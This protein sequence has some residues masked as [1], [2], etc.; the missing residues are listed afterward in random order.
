M[1]KVVKT[2]ESLARPVVEE[3]GLTLWDVEFV[4]E[5]GRWV[6]RVL[7]DCQDGVSVNQCQAVSLALDPLLDE[8]DPI[9]QSYVLQ[10]SSAGLERSLKRGGDFARFMGSLVEIRL[11]APH[12]DKKEW[13]GILTG[14][15]GQTISLENGVA[16]SMRQ[17][18]QVKTILREIKR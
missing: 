7:I 8:H 5:A 1:S 13:Q 12:E 17:V 15:D 2:V 14:Y 9:K 11:Y 16:F 10:V 6:L 18:A 4:K 3:L